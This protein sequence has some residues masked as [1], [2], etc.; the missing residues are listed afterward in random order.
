MFDERHV[1]ESTS[2]RFGSAWLYVATLSVAV[3]VLH[4]QWRFGGD[5]GNEV[6]GRWL[7]AAIGVCPGIYCLGR[8]LV[9][10]NERLTWALIGLGSTA[11]GLGGVYYLS[12][13]FHADTVP[14]PSPAD[15]G[16][17]AVYP[18]LYPGLVLLVRSRLTGFRKTLWLDGVIGGLAVASLATAFVFEAVLEGVGGS[19]AAVATNL[20]YPLGDAVLIA[21]VVFVAGMS[22]WRPGRDWLLI[23][24][25]LAVFFAGDSVYLVKAAEGTYSTGHLLDASWPVG[26][27]LLAFAASRQAPARRRVPDDGWVVLLMPVFFILAMVGL[28]VWDHAHPLNTLAIVLTSL[29]LTAGVARLAFTFAENMTMLRHSRSEAL[30]D[31]LTQLGNRR[32]LLIDLDRAFDGGRRQLLLLLD[33]NGFKHYNDTF[34]HLAGD[35]LLSRLARSLATSTAG[36]GRAYRPGGDEFCV[37]V[38]LGETAADEIV[39]SAISALSERGEGFEITASCGALVVPDEAASTSDALRI[40]DQRMYADKQAGR[41]SAQEQSSNV[42]LRVLAERQPELAA[43]MQRVSALAA[44]VATRLDLNHEQVRDVRVAAALHD[45]GKVAIPDTIL[46]KPEPLADDERAFIETHTLIGERIMG[47]APALAAAGKLVRSSHERFDGAGYPDRLVADDIPLGSR[48]IF[49][50]DAFDAMLSTRPYSQARTVDEAVAELDRCSGTQFDPRV[51]AAFA[52]EL[53]ASQ[54]VAA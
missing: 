28:E 30:T 34:G 47:A 25:G 50:C 27:L 5:L 42:L 20:A 46:Q 37:L 43:H 21:L 45:I 12:A 38:D 33:L 22:G 51:V 35:T 24:L 39:E 26:L 14:Y 19:H 44:R 1:N 54:S 52:R 17:L 6:I 53:A 36:R 8:A 41:P 49:V 15:A 48:I 9:R 23:G 4:T 18:L 11:W 31:Q 2:H 16:Y 10:R 13:Y 32:S 3:F 29:T 7:N 40:V